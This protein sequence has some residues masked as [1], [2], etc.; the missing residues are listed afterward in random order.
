MN[1]T[2]LLNDRL[3]Y[4]RFEKSPCLRTLVFIT[5]VL[6]TDWTSAGIRPAVAKEMGWTAD[7]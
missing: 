6:L 2:C 7:V 3:V 1:C 5:D 4:E